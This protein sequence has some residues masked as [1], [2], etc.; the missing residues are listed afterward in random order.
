MLNWK[1]QH[2]KASP[3]SKAE[4]RTKL[5]LHRIPRPS[6]NS[7]TQPRSPG[8]LV[9][10]LVRDGQDPADWKG[11]IQQEITQKRRHGEVEA[12]KI[13]ID[14]WAILPTVASQESHQPARGGGSFV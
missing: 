3:T 13:K 7:A 1:E 9:D 12:Q 8:G 10:S 6:K 2:L 5:C 14:T 4:E 11:Q